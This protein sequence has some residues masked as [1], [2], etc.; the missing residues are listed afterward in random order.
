MKTM[1]IGK[2]NKRITL[3]RL[4][5]VEDE[6]G[7]SAKK[8]T[9]IKTVWATLRPIRGKEFYDIQKIQSK[10]SHKCFIRYIDGIDSNCFIKYNDTIYSIESAIDI[11]FEHKMLE[12]H[13][14]ENVNKEMMPDE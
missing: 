8:L 5:D 4:A 2:L 12:I 7:Q 1:N 9:E 14:Y 11:D 3:M 6:L 10:V 13:C